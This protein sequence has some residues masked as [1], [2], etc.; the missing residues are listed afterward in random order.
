MHAIWQL[1]WHHWWSTKWCLV[2][3]S[4]FIPASSTGS[5]SRLHQVAPSSV[6]FM[7]TRFAWRTTPLGNVL[8]LR[9]W[10]LIHF[11]A[12]PWSHSGFEW[13]F[14]IV[15]VVERLLYSCRIFQSCTIPAQRSLSLFHKRTHYRVWFIDRAETE[16][17]QSK[18]YA[19]SA[20]YCCKWLTPF[21]DELSGPSDIYLS[22]QT[23][24]SY[25]LKSW[26]WML[27]VIPT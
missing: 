8:I 4:L 15:T 27:W 1:T 16:T 19:T 17:E 12:R 25:M 11:W 2:Y 6:Y 7:R 13:S 9:Q 14:I 23:C 24:S 21:L 26:V 5:Y 20:A 22:D 3:R 10:C 18:D